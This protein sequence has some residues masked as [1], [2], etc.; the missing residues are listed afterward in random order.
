VSGRETSSRPLTLDI[1]LAGD[2]LEFDYSVSINNAR[3]MSLR[4]V[5]RLDGSAGHIQDAQGPKIAAEKAQHAGPLEYSMTLEGP[6]RPTGVGE[7]EIVRR[8]K[9]RA[10]LP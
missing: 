4:F 9:R 7:H 10:T 5:A 8:T 1:C 6:N 3:T 2:A